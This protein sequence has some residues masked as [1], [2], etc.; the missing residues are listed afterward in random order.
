[1]NARFFI[2]TNVFV[3][4]V[5]ETDPAKA[6]TALHLL[7]FGRASRLGVISYQVVQEF[8]HV[9]TRKFRRPLRPLD[10]EAFLVQLFQPL[11]GVES[12]LDLFRRGLALQRE[13]RLPWYDALIV[14]AAQQAG[15]RTLY[16]EDL[17]N[18]QRFGALK[19]ENPF[20]AG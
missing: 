10:L 13:N 1:M 17:Q 11:V 2:D 19:V 7:Q 5:D 15:C 20:V 6:A 3:Y 14:A 9:A 4:A 8:F 16:T 12:S 18:G